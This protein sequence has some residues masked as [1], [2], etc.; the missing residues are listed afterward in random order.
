[1]VRLRWAGSVQVR[2]ACGP[3]GAAGDADFV[4]VKLRNARDVVVQAAHP[5]RR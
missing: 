2:G 5:A 3:H 1:M 4:K